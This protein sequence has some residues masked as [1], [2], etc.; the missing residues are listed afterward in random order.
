[1]PAN[2]QNPRLIVQ[3]CRGVYAYYPRTS[4]CISEV[5]LPVNREPYLY[6]GD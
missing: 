1:M 4:G 2:S 5:W 3:L 6:E